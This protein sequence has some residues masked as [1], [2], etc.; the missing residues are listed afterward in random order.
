MSFLDDAACENVLRDQH[1][2]V[3]GAWSSMKDQILVDGCKTCVC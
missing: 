1:V 3:A 2:K